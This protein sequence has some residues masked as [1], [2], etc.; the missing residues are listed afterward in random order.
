MKTG[1]SAVALAV[2]LLAILAL[3]FLVNRVNDHGFYAA[4]VRHPW[5][6]LHETLVV[7]RAG[8][9]R[10]GDS[11]LDPLV[12]MDSEHL[13]VG[14]A[15]QRALRVLDDFL[16]EDHQRLIQDPLKRAMLQHDL[17]GLF[18]WL[19]DPECDTFPEQRQKLIRRI[20]QV[21]RRIALP[22]EDIQQLPDNY[23]ALLASEVG[24]FGREPKVQANRSV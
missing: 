14:G 20:A 8:A 18:D 3:Q 9:R 2:L 6:V 15:H 1:N 16:A 17:W 21:I 10:Y 12:W 11:E 23:A 19:A 22:I 7:R 5:N 4:D 13:L 24:Q